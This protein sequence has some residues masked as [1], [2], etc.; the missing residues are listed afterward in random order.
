M[1]YRF[2][3]GDRVQIKAENPGDRKRMPKYIRGKIGVVHEVRGRFVNPVDHRDERPP[4]YSVR[5]DLGDLSG[6]SSP[7]DAV[8]V[9][10]F[11]DWMIP[12]GP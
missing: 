5:F 7:G 12:G 10:V 4:L 8:L 2:S 3:V 6:A 9:D 1:S 11:E